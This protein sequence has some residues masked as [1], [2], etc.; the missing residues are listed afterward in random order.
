[1]LAVSA[2]LSRLRSLLW[3][4]LRGSNSSCDVAALPGV[5]VVPPSASTQPSNSSPAAARAG[6]VPE[7]KPLHEPLGRSSPASQ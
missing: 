6:A 4:H 7:P 1:M 5:T 2:E 3:N